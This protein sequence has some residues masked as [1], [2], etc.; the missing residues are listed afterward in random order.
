MH[1][2]KE[3]RAGDTGRGEGKERSGSDGAGMGNRDEETRERLE[4]ETMVVRQASVDSNGIRGRDMGMEREGEDGEVTGKISKMGD[5]SRLGNTRVYGEGGDAED[6][7][8][9]ESCGKS[10][11]LRNGNGRRKGKR[12]S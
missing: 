9:G 3:W 10:L 12:S 7:A 8:E 2:V 4:Q 1:D 5:G 11:G 6:D